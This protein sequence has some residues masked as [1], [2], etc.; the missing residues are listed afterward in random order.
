MLGAEGQEMRVHRVVMASCSDYFRVMLTGE[1][2]ESREG[3]VDL[4]GVTAAGLRVVV[5][6]AYTGTLLYNL[7]KLPSHLR[8]FGSLLKD[9]HLNWV[10]SY[11][12][13]SYRSFL[14]YL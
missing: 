10:R 5:D 8:M 7:F 9:C 2:R 13:N 6:F 3:R 12:E 1:M 4:K 11:A 14:H